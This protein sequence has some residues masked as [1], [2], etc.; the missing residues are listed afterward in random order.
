MSDTTATSLPSRTL[1]LLSLLGFLCA[2]GLLSFGTYSGN[3]RWPLRNGI[4]YL[5]SLDPSS[6]SP[7][8]SWDK[9]AMWGMSDWRY[10]GG[11]SFR[12]AYN[13]NPLN[14]SNRH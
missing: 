11:T 2:L 7:G 4:H 10:A 9:A 13:H 3:P 12:V 14:P 1:R 5:V 8:S 6:F